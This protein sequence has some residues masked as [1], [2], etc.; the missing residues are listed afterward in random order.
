MSLF[1]DHVS[2]GALGDSFY[3]YLIK[4]WIQSNGQDE[5]GKRMYQEAV[6]HIVRKLL[7]RSEQSKLLY[8]CEMRYERQENKMDHLACFAGGMFGLGSAT[9]ADAETRRS[10][11]EI[12][13]DLT[14][15]CHESYNRTATGLGPESFR[16]TD[17]VEARAVRG[18]EKY[19][20]LRPEVVESYF[21]LWRLTKDE[22]YRQWAWEV[23]LALEKYCRVDGGFTGLRDVYNSSPNAPKDDVQQSFFFAELLKYLYLIFSDDQLIPLD[24]W[25]FNTEAHVLPIKDKNPAYPVSSNG[26]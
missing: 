20:I 6:E 2:V 4:A 12:A 23:V 24:Q 15:T 13:K 5:V 16:F 10:H 25:V 14:N 17:A 18:N 19:Y 3:E 1:T 7:K 26:P 8:L 11:M 9:F 22:K 21:Y